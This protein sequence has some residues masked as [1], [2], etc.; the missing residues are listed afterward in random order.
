MHMHA[1]LPACLYFLLIGLHHLSKATPIGQSNPNDATNDVDMYVDQDLD[2]SFLN[3]HEQEFPYMIDQPGAV[4]AENP[5]TARGS[6]WGT[7][8]KA[9]LS[10]SFRGILDR[11]IEEYLNQKSPSEQHLQ[12][13]GGMNKNVWGAWKRG[14]LS[15]DLSLQT[16][17]DMLR[18][19]GRASSQ[20]NNRNLLA[21]AG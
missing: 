7:D 17:G 21:N 12:K 15:V 13:R 4:I 8:H 6:L 10:K 19:S 3:N 5:F 11:A 2:L 9:M 16:L 18:H 14:G 20:I 1:T